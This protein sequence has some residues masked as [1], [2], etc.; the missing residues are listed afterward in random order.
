MAHEEI[1]KLIQ[2]AKREA[3]TVVVPGGTANISESDPRLRLLKEALLKLS[4]AMEKLL[5]DLE[6]K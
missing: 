6:T 1:R 5:D 2:D 4:A 3:T